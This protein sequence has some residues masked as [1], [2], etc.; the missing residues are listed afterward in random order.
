MLLLLVCCVAAAAAAAADTVQS[1]YRHGNR[2]THQDAAT[3]ITH[4][5]AS[6]AGTGQSAHLK[7][8]R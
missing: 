5:V 7:L 4:D 6:A 1:I 2:N 8:L 3:D